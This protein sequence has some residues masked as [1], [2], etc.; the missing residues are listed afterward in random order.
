MGRGNKTHLCED[1]TVLSL[2]WTIRERIL[3]KVISSIYINV[4]FIVFNFVENKKRTNKW[5]IE[6]AYVVISVKNNSE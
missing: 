5:K 4:T 3:N 2:Y 1:T 6:T